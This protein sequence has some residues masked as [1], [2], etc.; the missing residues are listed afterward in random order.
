MHYTKSIGKR[1]QA[2]KY[3]V[4]A[5]DQAISRGAFTDGFMFVESAVELAVTRP[6]L[7]VLLDVINRA[8]RDLNANGATKVPMSFGRRISRSFTVGNPWDQANN[9]IAAYLQL[10]L[11]VESAVEKLTVK[12]PEKRS[13]L[14]ADA[15]KNG[16]KTQHSAQLNW[17]P[18][19]VAS[20]MSDNSEMEDDHSDAAQQCC[21]VQ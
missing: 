14:M 21:S 13:E 11:N 8:L 18:S 9:R 19:Y 20:K 10:K 4:K 1:A 12:S 15:R 5:A 16:F 3:K 6:E 7:R 17:Q 2:F